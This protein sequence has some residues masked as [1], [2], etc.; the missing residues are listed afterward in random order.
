[1]DSERRKACS[2]RFFFVIVYLCIP[3]HVAGFEATDISAW[4]DVFCLHIVE[5]T[6]WVRLNRPGH[7]FHVFKVLF[8]LSC[9]VNVVVK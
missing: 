6:S 3:V 1:M 5:S 7:I 8:F 9:G 2:E 4:Y